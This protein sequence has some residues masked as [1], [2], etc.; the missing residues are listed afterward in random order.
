MA[1]WERC[2]AGCVI[3]H[4]AHRLIIPAAESIEIGPKNPT[5]A[6]EGYY[7]DFS[8]RC[9]LQPSI[10]CRSQPTWARR[11]MFDPYKQEQART[12]KS[13]QCIARH[14]LPLE[15]M[16]NRRISDK[17]RW[18]SRDDQLLTWYGSVVGPREFKGCNEVREPESSERRHHRAIIFIY[19]SRRG[20]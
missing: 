2:A 11:Q 12:H 3:C 13:T 19:R 16:V 9:C 15:W 14:R 4:A 5:V 17:H 1:T 6:L 7:K 10:C 20:G 18:L 8:R